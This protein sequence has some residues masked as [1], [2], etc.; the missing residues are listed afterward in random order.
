MDE[1]YII[2]ID[3]GTQSTKVSIFNTSGDAI[4]SA[5]QALRPTVARKPGYVEHPDDDLW[6]SLV[7]AANAVMQKFSGD[8]KDIIGIGLCTIR[9]CRVFVKADGTLAA[10]V[11]S[12]M[13]IRSYKPFAE[14]PPETKYV[15]TTT[16]YM[17]T[18]LTGKFYD[19]IGRAHV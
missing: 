9:C 7:V 17:G 10:P 8:K 4:C 11:M 15:T 13:D 3:G 16:G 14:F 1:K 5:T 18:R 2:S 19:K 6:D 12:W